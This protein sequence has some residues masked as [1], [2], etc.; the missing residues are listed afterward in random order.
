M[1]DGLKIFF[2]NV[3]F[4]LGLTNDA[5]TY[6]YF[7]THSRK[8]LSLL[9]KLRLKLSIKICQV[10][11]WVLRSPERANAGF[12]NGRLQSGHLHKLPERGPL[13]GLA[14]ASRADTQN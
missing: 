3:P 4:G 6:M 14:G 10:G 9:F 2:G 7:S 13:P 12:L 5:K 1:I 8:R 11:G